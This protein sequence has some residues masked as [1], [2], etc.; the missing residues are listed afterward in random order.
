[1]LEKIED[2]FKENGEDNKEIFKILLS[3]EYERLFFQTFLNESEANLINSKNNLSTITQ[4]ECWLN[5]V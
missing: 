2:V 3:E 5:K 4:T 1:M